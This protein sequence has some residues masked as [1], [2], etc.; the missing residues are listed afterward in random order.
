MRALDIA[1]SRDLPWVL[2][3]AGMN[4]LLAQYWT[5]K[6]YLLV[7]ASSEVTIVLVTC[8]FFASCSLGFLLASPSLVR[9]VSW[10]VLPLALIQLAFPWLLKEL[11]AL[12]YRVELP[13]VTAALLAV[14]VLC[15]APLYTILLPLL[16]AA[17]EA[18]HEPSRG[19]ALSVCY[20]VELAGALVG[21]LLILTIGR[22]H[23]VPLLVLYFLNVSVILAYIYGSKWVLVGAVPV[24]LSY[25]VISHALD[26][27]AT[28]AFYRS[29]GYPADC[30]LIDTAQSLY[31]RIDVLQDGSEDRLLVMNGRQYF[32]PDELEA[33][34]RYVAGLPS[35]LMPGSRVLIVGTGS[36]SSVYH[37]SR[38]AA[39]V[40]SV[41]ID[42]RVA[43]M[44]RKHF[45]RYHHLDEVS[46]WTLHID[47]AKHFL[48]SSAEVYDLIIVDMVP[49]VYVQTALLFTRE[50]YELARAR[51]SAR[52]VLS[53]YTG[54]WFGSESSTRPEVSTIKTIDA[55]FPEYLVVNSRTAGMAFV[56]AARELPFGKDALRR[57]LAAEGAQRDQLFD[58]TEA[59]P[60]L[61][62]K[63]ISSVSNLRMVL[64]WSPSSYHSLA[65]GF[66]GVQ[67]N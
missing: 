15:I 63:Q 52:G 67:V 44:G 64:E 5:M 2:L 38:W 48:A 16:V 21:I 4:L 31:N 20:G 18:D 29:R 32:N 41:E 34:N 40:E 36:L 25:G 37:A 62:G 61:E 30:R 1:T 27:P 35:E 56:Y 8:A 7:L 13:H 42:E 47:D 55:V 12:F 24:A 54:S 60:F 26:R 6:E 43:E 14:G 10:L 3:C 39:R 51:L 46:G 50:F 11:A 58:A 45:R 57:L 9:A 28:E 19:D 22:R 49:P 23:F 17:R 53:V 33:F 66:K 59:R 65:M